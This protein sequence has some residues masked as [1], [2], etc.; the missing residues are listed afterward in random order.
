MKGGQVDVPERIIKGRAVKME[1]KMCEVAASSSQLCHVPQSN[2]AAQIS[3]M[4]L[5]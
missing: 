5:D 2:T 4:E 1:A 3:V